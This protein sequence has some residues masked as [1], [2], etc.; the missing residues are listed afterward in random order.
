MGV[1]EHQARASPQ[2]VFEAFVSSP[3]R[4]RVCHQAAPLAS[5]LAHLEA[6]PHDVLV[7]RAISAPAIP[8]GYR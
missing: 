4:S 5:G 6:G 3:A 2:D 8:V 1:T 7:R